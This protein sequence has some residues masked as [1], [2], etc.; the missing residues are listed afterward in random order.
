MPLS[1][2]YYTESG[3]AVHYDSSQHAGRMKERVRLFAQS[4]GK[5]M[6]EDYLGM[7]LLRLEGLCTY[8]K[9]KA[10]EGDGNFQRMIDEGHLDH[11]EKDM[12][13]IREH[14]KEWI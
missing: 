5:S 10:K 1:R 8:M 2:V 9:R 12:K 13:F 4:Y 7:V 11:Y 3:E 6:D 14:G